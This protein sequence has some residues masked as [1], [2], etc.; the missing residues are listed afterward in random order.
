M[1]RRTYSSS[2]KPGLA[3]STRSSKCS[4]PRQRRSPSVSLWLKLGDGYAITPTT[5]AAPWPHKEV[6]L[7]V[8]CVAD[9]LAELPHKNFIG[10]PWRG[11]GSTFKAE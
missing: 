4:A 3:L 2:T 9:R 6:S 5:T 1:Q 11:R 10:M 8:D 7:A